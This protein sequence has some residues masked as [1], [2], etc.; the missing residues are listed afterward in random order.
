V[1]ER[2]EELRQTLTVHPEPN[3]FRRRLTVELSPTQGAHLREESQLS[4]GP[5]IFTALEELL[6]LKAEA[7]KGPVDVI[8]IDHIGQPSA[9]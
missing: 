9:N 6:G 1:A 3:G 7:R 5:S 2:N 8:V 4:V